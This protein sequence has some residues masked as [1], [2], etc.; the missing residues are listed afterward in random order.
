MAFMDGHRIYGTHT[1]L[2]SHGLHL[3]AMSDEGLLVLECNKGLGLLGVG[4]EQA[5][6]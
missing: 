3:D 1:P 4:D 5:Q 2:R 6:P